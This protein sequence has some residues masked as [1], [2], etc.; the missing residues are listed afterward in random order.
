MFCDF[1]FSIFGVKGD[2]EREWHGFFF[3]VVVS[4]SRRGA[5][6]GKAV[7][8]LYAVHGGVWNGCP[9]C[10]R[11]HGCKDVEG[12]RDVSITTYYIKEERKG[13][14]LRKSQK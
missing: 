3:C 14:G 7:Q 11:V 6:R 8:A 13:G 5:R 1:P 4:I 9:R 2:R 10:A 12:R